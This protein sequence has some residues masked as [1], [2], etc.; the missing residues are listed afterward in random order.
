MRLMKKLTFQPNDGGRS[1]FG[2]ASNHAGDCVVR[3]LAIT[4]GSSYMNMYEFCAKFAK[5]N[6]KGIRIKSTNVH[7]WYDKT[8]KK[9][10]RHFGFKFV[11]HRGLKPLQVPTRGKVVV[12]TPSHVTA[13][14]NGVVNDTQNG[15]NDLTLSL[16]KGYWIKK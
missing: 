6:E 8:L 12:W 13:V 14:V 9:L 11:A 2:Y 3:A 1:F 15:L 4:M 5:V 10:M 7:G 16:S